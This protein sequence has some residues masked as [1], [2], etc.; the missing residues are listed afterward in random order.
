MVDRKQ[1]ARRGHIVSLL[2]A[3]FLAVACAARTSDFFLTI[4]FGMFAFINFQVLQSLH[5][6]QSF[7]VYQDDDWWRR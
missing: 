4:F 6:A 7:G 5:Q 1:G 2:T 3:G